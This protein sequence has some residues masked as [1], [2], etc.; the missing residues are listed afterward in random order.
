L[1]KLPPLSPVVVNL[2]GGIEFPSFLIVGE[3]GLVL[4]TRKK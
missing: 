2:H 3:K 1:P 4:T